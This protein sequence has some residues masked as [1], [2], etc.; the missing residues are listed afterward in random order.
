MDTNLP[1]Y[2]VENEDGYESWTFL[3]DEEY[4]VLEEST[5][6]EQLN[7]IRNGDSTLSRQDFQ[8]LF[9]EIFS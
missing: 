3:N 6:E 5:V 4:E 9:A 8:E 2:R 1:I 7:A